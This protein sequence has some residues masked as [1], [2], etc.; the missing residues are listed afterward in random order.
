MLKAVIL[1]AGAFLLYSIILIAINNSQLVQELKLN[2][3]L[4]QENNRMLA[5]IRQKNPKQ[6]QYILEER[7]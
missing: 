2:N 3:Q 1:I 6:A 7:M 4:L 5:D